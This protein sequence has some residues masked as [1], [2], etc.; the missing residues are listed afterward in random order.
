VSTVDNMVV[1]RVFGGTSDVIYAEMLSR[2]LS[3]RSQSKH[4]HK[5]GVL[6]VEFVARTVLTV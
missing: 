4:R 1:L 6:D 5:A 3:H 2:Y